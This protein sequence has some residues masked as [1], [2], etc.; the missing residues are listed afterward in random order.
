MR[1]MQVLRDHEYSKKGSCREFIA[2]EILHF[3]WC[4][5]IESCALS[6]KLIF[7]LGLETLHTGKF[8]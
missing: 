2:T 6:G 7:E 1:I 5:L 8:Q 3:L 4:F